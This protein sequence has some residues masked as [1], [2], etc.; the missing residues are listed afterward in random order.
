M[1]ILDRLV[2]LSGAIAVV[3]FAIIVGFIASSLARGTHVWLALSVGGA[4]TIFFIDMF[5]G[6]V[7]RVFGKKRTSIVSWPVG[8]SYFISMGV[9]ICIYSIL[10][11]GYFAILSVLFLGIPVMAVGV[12]WLI[13]KEKM[14]IRIQSTDIDI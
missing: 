10:Y 2:F 12:V 7:L 3:F 8:A 5:I 6:F 11:F 9:L 13:R 1:T 14:P 4:T